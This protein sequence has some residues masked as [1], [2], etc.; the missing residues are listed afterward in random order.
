MAN[1]QP[2]EIIMAPFTVYWA[3]LGTTAPLVNVLV[4]VSPWIAIA[5][6]DNY[7]DSGVTLTHSDKTESVRGAGSTAIRKVSR[8]EEDLLV[9]FS[10]MD[11]TLANYRLALNSNLVTVYPAATG[12]PGSEK[13][14]GYQGVDVR[15]M[16]LLV[17]GLSPRSGDQSSFRQ[18]W[19]PNCFESGQ[20]KPQFAKGKAA[21]LELEFTAMV[22][23]YYNGDI[24]KFFTIEDY[25][26]PAL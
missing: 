26:A 13:L 6:L 10:I 11:V 17:R 18:L 22:N 7:D 9:N 15:T 2:Y 14:G 25:T 19:I 4:P 16:A 24:D 8:T 3:P 20:P 23:P 21:M 5:Q 1:A 12:V